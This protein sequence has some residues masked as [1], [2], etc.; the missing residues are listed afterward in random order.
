MNISEYSDII[1]ALQD[2]HWLPVHARIHFKILIIVFKAIHALATPYIRDL[3][4][5][6]SKPFTILNQIVVFYLSRLKRKC[7]LRL[8]PGVFML[9]RHV[10]GIVYRLTCVIFIHYVV[11]N[12][13]LRPIFFELTRTIFL[14]SYLFI[15]AFNYLF[16]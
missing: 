11:L 15:C 16:H 5:V 13:N 1:P 2:L 12:G 7:F 10:C 6:R 14:L 3:I 8:V 9:L 4:S